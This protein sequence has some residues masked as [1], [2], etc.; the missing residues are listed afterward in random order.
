[1][2]GGVTNMIN[3][4][5]AQSTDIDSDEDGTPNASD[6]TPFFLPSDVNLTISMTNVPPLMIRLNFNTIPHATNFVYYSTNMVA[7][8]WLLLTSFISPN[9]YRH[10]RRM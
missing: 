10:R 2:I 3:A 5:L 8:N 4:A 7:T 1:V 6:P 9:S